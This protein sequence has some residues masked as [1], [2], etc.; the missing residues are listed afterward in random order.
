MSAAR[1]MLSRGGISNA[2]SC[3]PGTRPP[4]AL[5]AGV[6]PVAVPVPGLLAG[7]GSFSLPVALATLAIV[8][9]WVT[10]TVR[11]QLAEVLAA[12]APAFQVRVGAAKV[13]PQSL[14]T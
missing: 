8:P 5:V 7:V 1:P 11:L 4:P 10:M 2:N 13:A 3:R 9:G 14:E 6:R 12:R